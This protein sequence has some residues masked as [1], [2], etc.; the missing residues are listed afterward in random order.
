MAA[1]K[2]PVDVRDLEGPAEQLAEIEAGGVVDMSDL[3]APVVNGPSQEDYNEALAFNNQIVE[4]RLAE[5]DDPNAE[6]PV[7]V[8]VNGRMVYIPRGVPV[9][10]RRCYIENLL[11]AINTNVRTEEVLDRGSDGVAERKSIIRKKHRL[12]YPFEMLRDP[13]GAKGRE[14]LVNLRASAA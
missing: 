7:P 13:A 8:G 2:K 12:H 11:R 6:D 4:I 10:L 5:S 14:W 9:K 3:V 1:R